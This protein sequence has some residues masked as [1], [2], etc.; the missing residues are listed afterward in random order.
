MTPYTYRDIAKMIDH[1]LLQPQLTDAELEAGCKVALEYDVASVCIKPY[2]VRRA[3]EILKGSTI[4]VGTTIVVTSLLGCLHPPAGA[5]ARGNRMAMGI[6]RWPGARSR[7]WPVS[8]R[9]GAPI[10]SGRLNPRNRRVP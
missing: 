10:A 8:G 4:A 5:V 3:S 1:S 9:T 2:Y 7:R 6:S